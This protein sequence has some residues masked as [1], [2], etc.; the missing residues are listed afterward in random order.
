MPKIEVY[1]DV[2]V[3]SIG[4]GSLSDH[5]LEEIFP[6]AKAELDEPADANGIMKVELN[7]TNRPDL[8]ST[9]GLGRQLRIYK[10]AGAPKYTFFSD[11]SVRREHGNRRVV[12]DKSVQKVRPWVVGFVMTGKPISEAMLK[13]LIQTQE[14][15]TWNYG[16][17]RRSIAMGVYRSDLI[18]YPVHY[19]AVDPDTTRFTP[20]QS[21]RE[22]SMREILTEHPKGQEFGHIVADEKLFPLLTDDDGEVLSFPPVINSATLGA[23]QEGDAS[24]FIELTGSD[25]DSLLHAASIVACD[26]DDMGYT[27]EPVQVEYPYDTPYGRNI[28][29]PYYFQK[30]QSAALSEI[31]ALLGETL[32]LDEVVTALK[33]MGITAT[34]I[35]G[36]TGT[37]GSAEVL[38]RVPEYRNDFLHAVD[39]VEDVM[40]G[41]GM[42]SFAPE[43]PRD[44]TVGRLTPLEEFTR[45]IKSTMVGLGFQEMIFNYLGSGKDYIELMYDEL[46]REAAF[47]RAVRIANPMSENYE[48]VRPSV[49]PSLLA[50]ESVSGNA[51]YPHHI[52]ESGK[53]AVRDDDEVTGTATRT[54]LGFLSADREAGFNMINSHVSA[55]LFYMGRDYELRDVRDSRFIPGRAAQIVAPG[56]G[57]KGKAPSVLGVFGELH[58]R[59]LENWGV[60]VPCTAGELILERLLEQGGRGSTD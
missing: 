37:R 59:V 27:V 3:S 8:W 44:F 2:L 23:V 6:A 32:S 24:L 36:S 41:R 35:A 30:P 17:K 49:L 16:R 12:V 56:T 40:I 46:D 50:S 34:E 22:L 57:K 20:L 47:A 45:R 25:L 39:I 21:D 33:H 51:V 31:N 9:A 53:V 11:A 54:T 48:Y 43:M 29:V 18:A 38:I 52:F 60:Q 5:Q 14:K 10:G 28:T 7:D 58:P 1:R 26:I 4:A 15:L 42:D 19:R 55:I 13:D